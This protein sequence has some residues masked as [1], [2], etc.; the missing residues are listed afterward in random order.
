MSTIKSTQ[1]L[2]VRVDILSMADALAKI[3]SFIEQGGPHLVVTADASAIV[4]AQKDHEF[5]EIVQNAS[6]VTPDGIGVVWAANRQGTPMIER[7]S[8]ADLVARVCEEGAKRGHRFYF[9]GSAPGIAEAA[10]ENLEKKYPGMQVVGARDGFFTHEQEPQIAQEIASK[11]PHYLFVAMGI[12]KQEKF[13]AQYQSILNVPVMI[14]VGGTLD[15]YSGKVKRAPMLFRKLNLE[16]LWRTVSNPKKIRKAATLP[17]FVRL[18]LTKVQK[19][20]S[21]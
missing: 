2:G 11:K 1:I 13:I 15:V 10:A 20:H 8:G 3:Q 14:G 9:L 16:W 12:P 21:K 7:V 18:V 17:I 5:R 4:I 6:L 19:N